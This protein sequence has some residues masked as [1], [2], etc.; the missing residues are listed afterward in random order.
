MPPF[1]SILVLTF[2]SFIFIYFV[3]NDF[4]KKKLQELLTLILKRIAV[5]GI[6]S[7]NRIKNALC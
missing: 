4:N 1:A 5:E 2:F 6:I 7:F 3:L